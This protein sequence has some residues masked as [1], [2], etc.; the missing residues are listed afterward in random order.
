MVASRQAAIPAGE[1]AEVVPA[2]Q[3]SAFIHFSD[4]FRKFQDHVDHHIGYQVLHI[5]PTDKVKESER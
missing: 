2:T 1:A 3:E 5:R 4:D